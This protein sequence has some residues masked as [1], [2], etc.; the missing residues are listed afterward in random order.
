MNSADR[1]IAGMLRQIAS[2]DVAE[3]GRP[4]TATKGLASLVHVAEH[5]GFQYWQA[6]R[7]G[8]E[9]KEV[10][11]VLYRDT[12]PEARQREAAT[13]AAFPGAGAGGPAPGMRQGTLEPLPEAAEAVALARTRL[14]HDILGSGASAGQKA[15][16]WGAG[17]VALLASLLD[18]KHITAKLVCGAVLAVFLAAC[19][20]IGAVRR[21]RMAERLRRAGFVPV[22]DASGRDRLLAPGQRLPEHAGPFGAGAPGAR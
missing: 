21:E 15:V 2:Q 10:R 18:G 3:L 7:A 17:A 14:R 4:L 13:V 11:V 19:F 16:A 22:R 9:G 1:E 8:P 5:Y 12:R 6:H 20:R